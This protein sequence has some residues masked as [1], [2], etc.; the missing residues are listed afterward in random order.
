MFSI[1]TALAIASIS[2]PL[3]ASLGIGKSHLLQYFF[4]MTT[5][6]KI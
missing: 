4:P 2:E 1:N 3:E 6:N 5:F